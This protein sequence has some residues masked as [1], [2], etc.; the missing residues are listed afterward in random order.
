MSFNC[1][2]GS[3][4]HE[5]RMDVGQ[6]AIIEE[7][8]RHYN[9]LVCP[10]AAAALFLSSCFISTTTFFYNSRRTTG[11]L[12]RTLFFLFLKNWIKKTT[13]TKVKTG[14][15]CGH[16]A[17]PQHSLLEKSPFYS[18]FFV[19]ASSTDKKTTTK[20]GHY[21]FCQII[22]SSSSAT[23]IHEIDQKKMGRLPKY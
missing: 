20:T 13:L 5:Q 15:S 1:H 19:A 17:K 11:I 9:S 12:P 21:S 22:F 18:F 23:V 6:A 7:N 2:L 14:L 16:W 8:S 3:S 4:S 10:F